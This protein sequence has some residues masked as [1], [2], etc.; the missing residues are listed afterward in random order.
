VRDEV[1]D[2]ITTLSN[3]T[4]L[5]V[6]RLL[7]WAGIAP[8][9]FYRWRERYGRANE[10]NGQVPRDHWLLEWEQQAI[11]AYHAKHPLD[12]YRRLTFMMNDDDL[13]AASPSSVYRVLR[14]AGVLDRY[15]NKPTKKG[16]GF[17]QPEAPHEHWHIDVT[18]INIAGTFY[19]LAA[20]LDGYSR[21]LVHW[22]LRESMTEKDIE[23]ILQRARERFPHARPRIVSDN[24]PQFIARDFRTFIRICGMTHVRTSPY[25]PQSNGKFERFNR[26]LKTTTIRRKTPATIEEARR[27]VGEFVEHYNNE[28]LH[29][30]IGYVTPADKMSGREN[31]IWA[32]RD[33]R[34]EAARER[35]ATARQQARACEPSPLTSTALH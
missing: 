2:F 11:L 4:E 35:R 18:Y 26:T 15:P 19:Y 31:D 30:A 28:R 27:L 22:E 23:T 20:L 25:Y 32:A 33:R 17:H 14:R 21:Y 13:V 3:K 7:G 8:A 12:G 24:G 34:L 10:H 16:T 6:R 29:S 9:K 1:V 5:P